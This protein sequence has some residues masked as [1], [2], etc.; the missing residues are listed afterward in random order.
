MCFFERT[1]LGRKGMVEISLYPHFERFVV[2]IRDANFES[3]LQDI[4]LFQ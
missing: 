4:Q 1:F 2:D 3:H